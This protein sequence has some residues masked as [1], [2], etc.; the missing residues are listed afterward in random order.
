MNDVKHK[1]ARADDCAGQFKCRQN[2]AGSSSNSSSSAIW[3]HKFAQKCGFKGPWDG[4][5]E[6][7]KNAINRLENKCSRID[8]AFD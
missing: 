3:A 4:T 2:F 6:L 8:D 7:I 5:N 1:V